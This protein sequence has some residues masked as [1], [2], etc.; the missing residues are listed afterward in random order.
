MTLALA[1]GVSLAGI[2]T[3]DLGAAPPGFSLIPFKRVDGDPDKS[4]ELT[5]ENGP[6]TIFAT[7]FAGEG[8]EKQA[9]D[10]I[11][12]LR[13]KHKLPAYM[14]KQHYDFTDNVQGLGVNKYGDPKKMKY[15]RATKEFDEI[16]VMVGNYA[17]LEDSELQKTLQK[18]K[19]LKPQCL[20]RSGKKATTQRYATLREFQK[21]VTPDKDAKVKG[22]MAKAFATRNPLL[23]EDYD[24]IRGLDPAVVDWNRNAEFSLL[25]NPGK[26]TVKVATFRGVSTW[27]KD[28]IEQLER[29]Q[30]RS[31][32][33]E[34]A[35]KA[36]KLA[37]ALRTQGVEAYEFHD[38][39]E[40]IVCIGSFDSVGSPR[41]DGKI[42]INPAVHKIMKEYGAQ[43]LQLP[44]QANLG[45]QPR[46]LKGINFDVQ[47][48]AVEVPR[49]SVA[50]NLSRGLL[51]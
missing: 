50:A 28:E 51:Q 24:A 10:L 21:M 35:T 27:K 17:G 49:V 19:F 23:P 38:R 44:G 39:N 33:E 8:A 45:L 18:I 43:Q 5:A 15:A 37:K 1:L 40:S 26:Y 41:A 4:Y 6:W 36:N 47:P 32:L 30:M 7:S 2:W 29:G 14:H 11:I 25:S 3:A 31:R 12:E 20:D 9:H 48:I 42:E 22:P 34:A 16:A 46:Q 13:Q